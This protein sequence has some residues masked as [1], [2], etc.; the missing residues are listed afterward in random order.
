MVEPILKVSDI[1]TGYPFN[2]STLKATLGCGVN[3]IETSEMYGRGNNEILIGN[4]IRDFEREKLFIVTKLAYS[5]KEYES[6]QD[7]IAEQMPA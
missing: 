7:I 6:A 1:G 2:E 3:L 5:V 4:V